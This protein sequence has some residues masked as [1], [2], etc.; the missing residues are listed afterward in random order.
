MTTVGVIG[1]GYVGL[2]LAVAFAEAGHDVIGVDSNAT[3]VASL[4]AGVSHIEDIPS[5]QLAAVARRAEFTTMAQRLSLA[6]A[7]LIC[8]P[9]P[10]T[11]QR[12][13]DLG[14][15]LSA[16]GATAGAL[17]RGQLV[18]LESTT[19]PGTTRERLL[20][21]LEETGLSV[22]RD[23]HLAFSPER[24]D[25]GS[26]GRSLGSTPK[27]VGGVTPACTERAVA[28]YADVC[29][30]VVPV[31]SPETAEMAKLLEN[32]F[33]S[34]NIALVN[35]LAMLADRMD[36]D[37]WEVVDAAATKPFG[38]MRFDPGPGMGGHCL[39][40]DPFYLTWKA[41][42]YDVATEFIELAG[43]VNQTM[44]NFCVEKIE[45]A[46][47]DDARAVRGAKVLVLGVA[48]KGGVGD[49]RESPALK[50][51]QRLRERGADLAYHDPYVPELA[52][53]GLSSE[54]DLDAALRRADLAVIVT[55]HPGVDHHAVAR[56][57]ATV[58]LRGVTRAAV[59]SAA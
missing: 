9:T 22:G 38:F 11:A 32:I 44:P 27:I 26:I 40:V 36:I 50:I 3:R 49:I 59:V 31:S 18:V 55:A 33:R 17:R 37:I 41:R 42:E 51:M 21:L 25:P 13:P 46:L 5:D 58:D 39:P 24:V 34:V 16:A 29:P 45:R 30:E 4:R 8:V 15:L 56:S 10:L 12:E 6:D 57:V 48:Y 53:L 20:P 1:L 23:F 47:N 43:K 19:Y 7:V 35:E 52:G 28:L 14:P 2:P 54:A